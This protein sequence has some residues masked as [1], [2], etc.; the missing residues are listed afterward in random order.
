MSDPVLIAADP[1]RSVW[2]AANAG[3]GKTYALAARVTRL[4]LAGA[5]PE[6]ILCLTYTKAAAAEMAARLFDQLGSWA[7]LPDAT[8]RARIAAIGGDA[9]QAE[10]LRKARRLF[11]AALETP[12]GLKIQTIHSFC[13]SVLM[14]FP[15]E[16]GVPAAFTVLDERTARDL[17]AEARTRVFE[18]AGR[19]DA[20]RAAALAHLV[21]SLSDVR[22]AKILDAALGTDQAKA[23]A[24]L[25]RFGTDVA[26][27]LAAL[28]TAHG[29]QADDTVEVVRADFFR[30]FAADAETWRQT[31]VWLAA[32]TKTDAARAAYLRTAVEAPTPPPCYV[33][34]FAALLTQKGEVRDR[35]A[36][37]K[38][39]QARPDLVDFLQ[40]QANVLCGCE[41]R[42]RAVRAAA[43]TDAALTVIAAV[44]DEYAV[45]K[46]ARGALDYDDLIVRTQ[47]LLKDGGARWVLY[48]LDQGL[49]HILID[50]AQDTSASQWDIVQALSDEFFA[51][52][53]AR[54]ETRTLFAVGDEKQSIF[55]FQGA[56][57]TQFDRRRRFF[58]AE[59]EAA[60]RAFSS[61][62]LPVSRR[63]APEI[64]RFVDAVFASD[65]AR[66]GLTASAAGIHHEPFRFDLQGKV[67]FWP[68]LRPN[69]KS[70]ADPWDLR[71]LDLVGEDAPLARLAEQ[72]AER[73]A[74]WLR[75]R[76]ALPGKTLPISPGDIMI[77]L[78]RREPFAGEIIRRLKNKG[79]PVAGADRLRLGEQIAI[80]DLVA[81][82]R[83]ALLPE[84]DLNLAAL[85]RSPLI[86]L[87]EEALYAV[88]HGREGHLWRA[89]SAA[90]DRGPDYAAAVVFLDAARA[91]AD[92]TPPFEFFAQALGEKRTAI[93]RRLGPETADAI[94]E[95]QSLAL[96]YERAGTPSL[97]GFLHWFERGGAEVKRDMDRSRGEVR[98]MTV[99]GSKGLE[100]DIVILPDT[101]TLPDERVGA[102][103]LLYTDGMALFPLS[104]ETAPAKVIAAKADALS[105]VLKE[106]RRL[107]YVALTRARQ[108]LCICGFENRRGTADGSWYR[109]AEAA[110]KRLGATDARGV[111]S[112]GAGDATPAV[113]IPLPPA[114]PVV[115][116][117][118]YKNPS[119]EDVRPRLIR[120]SQAAAEKEP[121]PQRP[122]AKSSGWRRGTLV[123]ALLAK[124]PDVEAAR[125]R[126]VALQFLR[127]RGMDDAESDV[128]TTQI[129][130]V[131]SYPSFAEAFAPGS[132]AEVALAA[133]LPELGPGVRVHG[134][135]DRLWV[136]PRKVLVVDFKTNRQPPVA[137]DRIPAY[138]MTQM[139]LYRLALR[140][141]FPNRRIVCALIWTEGPQLMQIEDIFLDAE[142][143]RIHER[144][145]NAGMV[146]K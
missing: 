135:I 21:G 76:V 98:V 57:P 71:P 93:L 44:R 3:A 126:D 62:V 86:G 46:R 74:G 72:I 51:G 25:A 80:R 27:R 29:A 90:R 108:R 107:L 69:A 48:K 41:N 102:D 95:F 87:S 119:T 2:V 10:E 104:K 9:T 23:A 4:L 42:L 15:L 99:H 37:K 121:P 36:T 118:V 106:R 55:S 61:V 39:A 63:S 11:A 14:R 35:L 82:G 77:L 59:A 12:G 1:A 140:K 81:L 7:M 139:S 53:G 84:D 112:F 89:L 66:E 110:A 16:A 32:G 100:A 70:T 133:D 109:L 132:R 20:P 141:I 60:G 78:P 30:R 131:A 28:K 125:Q 97:E 114:P 52:E 54:A 111:I 116:S 128:L 115:P 145:T 73:I 22:V 68:A 83:F 18:R 43:L 105:E 17:L 120:P 130:A 65:A 40:R 75:D 64:L 19:G 13:Q 94:A 142:T 31:V 137:A 138:Y 96:V 85:L 143:R 8:L 47:A 123:H 6:R 124:L 117:W 113:A 38:L 26:A 5:R 67:E 88:A 91:R 146:L 92:L 144:L 103:H 56:D 136:G 33:A 134:R 58:A 50:E 122:L 49:D 34:V 45:E 79:V 24:V 101:T 127:R 129:L